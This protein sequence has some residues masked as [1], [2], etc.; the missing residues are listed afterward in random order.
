VIDGR[1]VLGE[2]LGRGA[3]GEVWDALD[4]STGARVA[5]KWLR[6]EAARE[7]DVIDRFVR[8]G[9]LA[10]RVDSAHVCRLV[11]E[12]AVSGAPYLV[13]ERLEGEPLSERL[14]RARALSAAE[15][16]AIVEQLLEGL[17]AAH[18]VDVVHRDLKPSNVFLVRAPRGPLVKI[19]D[20]GVAKLLSDRNVSTTEGVVLGSVPYMAPEQIGASAR[21]DAR[22]DVYAAG[23]LAFRMLSGRVP[24]EGSAVSVLARK[25]VSVA[26]TLAS[27]TGREWP[28][29]M[30]AFVARSLAIHPDGR[31]PSARL[32]LD[33]WREACRAPS[34]PPEIPVHIDDEADTITVAAP[35]K[36]TKAPR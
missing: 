8:E 13:F 35:R 1:F 20:F 3:V 18:A 9:K 25:G 4:R 15:V 11:A 36:R 21:A 5:L 7:P 19:L 2:P 32:A 33:A 24:F 14:A 30:E 34:P 26:P 31:Y 16:A 17:A 23:V 12:G 22:A 28:S 27:A 6:P 29:E 10:R